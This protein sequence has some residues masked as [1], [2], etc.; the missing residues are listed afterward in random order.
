LTEKKINLKSKHMERGPQNWMFN[1]GYFQLSEGRR[2]RTGHLE[3]GGETKE[4]LLRSLSQNH[5]I[6]SP[7]ALDVINKNIV[8]SE[9]RLEINIVRISAWDMDI[10]KRIPRS[11]LF[12]KAFDAGLELCPLETAVYLR[13]A[14]TRQKINTAYSV[15]SEPMVDPNRR[16]RI[17]RLAN[18][19]GDLELNALW[20]GPFDKIWSID[21][22]FVFRV[23]SR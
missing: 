2:F 17:F 1:D 7:F 16:K 11:Q 3:I 14:D 20:P 9:D 13:L 21:E 8:F 12:K 4:G 22:N 10:N 23:K 6:V 18:N 5:I 15:A 19:R